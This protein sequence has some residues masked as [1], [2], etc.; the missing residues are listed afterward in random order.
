MPR[1]GLTHSRTCKS[2]ATTL[3][4]IDAVA[5]PTSWVLV[6]M[7]VVLVAGVLV[8]GLLRRATGWR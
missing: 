3:A 4:S 7:A 2:L 8:D 5:L 1:D 6:G